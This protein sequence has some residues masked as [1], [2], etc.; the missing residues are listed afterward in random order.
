MA[1]PFSP[2]SLRLI[3]GNNCSPMRWSGYLIFVSGSLL[4]LEK[5]TQAIWG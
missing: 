3:H 1:G 4:I 5:V 2:K